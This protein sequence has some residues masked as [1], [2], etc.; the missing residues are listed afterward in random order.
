MLVGDELLLLR[1]QCSAYCR[2]YLESVFGHRGVEPPTHRTYIH[3]FTCTFKISQR[4]FSPEEKQLEREADHSPS[5]SED[6]LMSGVLPSV[7]HMP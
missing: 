3:T 6:I 4:V 5:S 1:T 2:F 7:P